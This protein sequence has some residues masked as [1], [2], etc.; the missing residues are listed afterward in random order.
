[1]QVR[2]TFPA[3]KIVET[4]TSEGVASGQQA[5][6]PQMV[7]HYT[8]AAGEAVVAKHGE[9]HDVPD[10]LYRR[11]LKPYG[12]AEPVASVVPNAGPEGKAESKKPEKPEKPAK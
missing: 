1:M 4:V 2:M 9:V 5:P 7:F 10:D 11:C 12:L 6:M 8:T 3:P